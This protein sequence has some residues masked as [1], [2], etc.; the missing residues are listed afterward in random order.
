MLQSWNKFCFSSGYIEV[1]VVLPGPDE[2]TRGYV[3]T[4]SLVFSSF[5]ADDEATIALGS[6]GGLMGWL[7]KWLL[8]TLFGS[9]A[10][11]FFGLGDLLLAHFVSFR[12]S[13]PLC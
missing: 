1:N 12:L 3:S 9:F 8:R 10:G 7:G 5:L 11:V 2:N 6:W 13:L 4:D